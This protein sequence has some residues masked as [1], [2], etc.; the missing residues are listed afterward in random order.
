MNLSKNKQLFLSDRLLIIYNL[1]KNYRSIVDFGCD[2]GKILLNLYLNF[3]DKHFLTAVDN[4]SLPLNNCKNNFEKLFQSPKNVSYLQIDK[5]SSLPLNHYNCV[6]ISGVGVNTINEILKNNHHVTVDYFIFNV[7]KKID[8]LRFIIFSFD[9]YIEKEYFILE[10]NIY[11][12]ICKVN[13]KKKFKVFTLVDL[14]LGNKL[15]F[16]NNQ[17]YYDYLH[18]NYQKIKLNKNISAQKLKIINNYLT[19]FF[20]YET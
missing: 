9:W 7:D 10:N 20:S 15:R 17:F 3:K 12:Y 11:Q 2:H 4:K 16:E 8:R 6:I 18:K 5:I 1:V 14:Y 19:T 13:T